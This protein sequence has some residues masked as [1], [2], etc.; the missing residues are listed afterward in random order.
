MAARTGA[1]CR[2]PRSR[3][4]PPQPETGR[5]RVGKKR[6]TAVNLSLDFPD[7]SVSKA[8][9]RPT[10]LPGAVQRFEQL[11][12][13]PDSPIR[14]IRRQ[15]AREGEFEDI[16]GDVAPA[17]ADVLRQRGISRLY[18]HQAEAF[19]LAR[20]GANVVAVTPTASGK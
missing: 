3:S 14:A 8:F 10:G 4:R 15:A 5:D 18:T 17:I 9:A 13:N 20:S 12:A 19:A 1:D 2:N 6:R 7:P 11:M 16:P